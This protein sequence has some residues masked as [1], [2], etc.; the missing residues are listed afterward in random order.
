MSAKIEIIVIIVLYVAWEI[1]LELTFGA[2][3]AQAQQGLVERFDDLYLQTIENCM[4]LGDTRDDCMRAA[5]STH[6]AVYFVNSP[7]FSAIATAL[8]YLGVIR[9]LVVG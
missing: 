9:R 1:F 7:V 6:W 8:S 5:D 3:I 2:A 4:K